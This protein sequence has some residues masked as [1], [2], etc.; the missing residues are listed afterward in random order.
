MVWYLKH[1]I[2]DSLPPVTGRSCHKCGFSF[3]LRQNTFVTTNICNGK[4]VE[5]GYIHF[6]THTPTH[7]KYM[8]YWWW[9]GKMTDQYAEEKR[10][11]FSFDLKEESELVKT[12]AWQ[13][14]EGCSRAHV[15]CIV[16]ISPR[17]LLPI[18]GTRKM[19][20]STAKQRE[21]E[22]E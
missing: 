21:R 9:I 15:Q 17:A 16:R 19:R 20:V 5:W 2:Y 8:H 3:L 12:N 10:C 22:G 11:V 4:H 1:L 7:C 18:L 14:E 6:I 13:R